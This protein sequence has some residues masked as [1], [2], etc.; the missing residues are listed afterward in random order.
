[1]S[2]ILISFLGTGTY[3]EQRS[4]RSYNQVNYRFGDKEVKTPLISVALTDM[5]KPD[6]VVIAGTM[7]SAW[8]VLYFELA[9]AQN[10]LDEAAWQRIIQT[11]DKSNHQTEPDAARLKD[12]LPLLPD[13]S[14]IL[15]LKYGISAAELHYNFAQLMKL[16]EIVQSGDTIYLDITHGFRSLPIFGVSVVSYLLQSTQKSVK[17][18]G[19]YYGMLEV[20]REFNYAPVVDLTE[21]FNLL[22]WSRAA[23]D[24]SQY[25]DTTLLS[26]LLKNEQN[27][28]ELSGAARQWSVAV[29]TNDTQ[30]LYKSSK[31][32]I[33][34]TEQTKNEIATGHPFYYLADELAAG[35]RALAAS[36]MEW[37]RLMILS[38]KQARLQQFG[39]AALSCWEAVI[40]RLELALNRK[41]SDGKYHYNI[42]SGI[43]EGRYQRLP[44][45]E[46]DEEWFPKVE[47]LKDIRNKIAHADVSFLQFPVNLEKEV[48][49][50]VNYFARVLALKSW[51]KLDGKPYQKHFE[52]LQI[53]I[54]NVIAILNSPVLTAHGQYSYK[55][56]SVT[57][58]RDLVQQAN[59]QSYVGHETTCKF[60]SELLHCHVPYNRELY[61]QKPGEKAI[62]FRLLTRLP[63]GAV[64]SELKDVEFEIGL[65]EM[66]VNS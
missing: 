35:A 63:E 57:E 18:G 65:L 45:K 7:R 41:A 42:L 60:L 16:E 64:L 56:L 31:K 17:L 33:E 28:E 39:L 1:M 53:C 26:D 62:V 3:T 30:S 24:F 6:K 12:I 37:Q 52:N 23:S 2:K 47:Q 55:P 20:I 10:A 22:N 43:A 27:F 29:N 40:A 44:L 61:R 36:N 48:P 21:T 38:E 15:P 19:V 46:I 4:N 66:K 49:G 5:I 9:N 50:L 34:T 54:T 58:A 59:I 13:G 11:T 8:E 14:V 32:L 25:G 51:G